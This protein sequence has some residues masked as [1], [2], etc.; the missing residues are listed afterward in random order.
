MFS[1]QQYTLIFASVL[2][3]G[4]L[5]NHQT[6]YPFTVTILHNNDGE[7][8]LL[9]A[10]SGI[11]N[12]GGVDRFTT[13]VNDLRNNATTDAVLTLSSGDNFLAGPEFNAS[14]A[15]GSMGSRIYYDALALGNIGYDAIILGNHDFDFGPDL[16]ADF[17]AFYNN[18]TVNAAPYLS[19]NLDF[20]GEANLQNLVNMGQIASSAIVEKGGQKIGIIGA[21]TPNLPFISSP[22]NVSV[23]QDVKTVVQGEIDRLTTEEGVNKIILVSHLQGVNED[24]ALISQLQGVD[25]AIAGGGDEILANPDDQLVPGDSRQ[26]DYPR[27]V[28]DINGN[29]VP[30]VTTAGNYKYVGQLVVEFDDNGELLSIDA[31]SGPVV[32]A[33]TGA[34]AG[35]GNPVTQTVVGDPTVQSQINDPVQNFVDSLANN[36]IA[37]S[38]VNLDGRRNAIRSQETNEGNLVAD[39]ILFQANQSA[40]GFGLGS[41]DIALTNGGGIRNDTIIPAGDISE[42][43]TF[44]ILPFGNF[45]SIFP[46]ITPTQL[47]TILENAVASISLMDNEANIDGASGTGRF[48]QIAGFNFTYNPTET[49]IEIDGDGNITIPGSRIIDVTLED[50]TKLIEKGRILGNAP[51]VSVATVDFLARGG[52]QY[53]FGD[54]PF[55]NV[56]VTYQQALANYI[57]SSL[58]LNGVISAADYPEGGEGRISLTTQTVVSTPEPSSLLGLGLL[59][60]GFVVKR[61]VLK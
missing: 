14:L 35:D 10:G 6:A 3:W 50:G 45:V 58:G 5:F 12:F 60:L 48:A 11:E 30:L 51:S 36:I 16:L 31:G 20:S 26:D 55:T 22:G 39:A 4:V 61:K 23:N 13:L 25:I 54:T 21:T 27:I 34:I 15:T 53:P 47:K 44:D 33:G 59:V 19:A 29:D 41:V 28:Q 56:G 43:D 40:A 42:L 52:D 2:S 8:Q 49:P 57:E 1:K 24:E 17:I 32:V 38:E 9:N 18:N 46:E 7:S 37:V